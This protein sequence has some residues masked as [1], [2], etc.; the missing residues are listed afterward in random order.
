MNSFFNQQSITSEITDE[1]GIDKESYIPAYIQ[2]SKILRRRISSGKYI[3]GSRLASELSL[4]KQFGISAMTAR[5][6]V[7]DLVKDGLV[8]RVQGSGTFVQK[9]SIS[10]SNF[11]LDAL[12]EVFK[13]KNNIKVQILK[14]TVESVAGPPIQALQLEKETRLLVVERLI[15]HKNSPFSIQIGYAIS[16][17]KSP[18]IETMLDT[19]MLTGLFFEEGPSC[20]MKGVLRLLPTAFSKKEADLLDD[21][22]GNHAFKLEHIYYDFSGQPASYGWFIVSPEKMPVFTKVGIWNN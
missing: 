7:N 18:I 2:L 14:A 10:S 8:K 21:S 4:A 22:E 1:E 13:D 12:K 3:P 5:Q 9:I 19:D 16:D 6:A 17:P 20:F 11:T 15:L